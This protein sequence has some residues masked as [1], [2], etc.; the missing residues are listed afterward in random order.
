M[1]L[2]NLCDMKVWLEGREVGR[3]FRRL[4]VTTRSWPMLASLY[5]TFAIRD[6]RPTTPPTPPYA[7]LLVL[8]LLS[9]Y[10]HAGRVP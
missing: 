1:W 10:F 4:H 3:D 9:P 2:V 8:L 5:S 6:S 7:L